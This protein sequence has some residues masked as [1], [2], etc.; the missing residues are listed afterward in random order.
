MAKPVLRLFRDHGRRQTDTETAPA[1]VLLVIAFGDPYQVG[2]GVG[3]LATRKSGFVVGAQSQHGRSTLTGTA[4]GVQVDLSWSHAAAIFGPQLAELA[5]LAVALP[6]L[7]GGAEL[8]DRLPG[9][10]T[11]DRA[12]LV[13]DWLVAS[14][15]YVVPS[16]VVD[17]ALSRIEDG[18]PSVGQ[19]AIEL[20]CSRGYL[21]RAV[22]AATGQPPSMLI[23]I[24]RL[25]RLIG[26]R[27]VT[28]PRES[29]AQTAA[30]VGYADRAHLCHEA[31][32]L[33]GR[34]PTEL[35]EIR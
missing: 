17:R 16:P 23:R 13:H 15:S 3:E 24:V 2:I 5:D 27:A 19:L 32:Q 26:L 20:G 22:R 29:L 30:Q 4:E 33:A 11:T 35:L 7:A 8:V 1:G 12:R 10:P 9:T 28:D 14:R 18:A 31:R 25:H 6:D 34:T 21:H